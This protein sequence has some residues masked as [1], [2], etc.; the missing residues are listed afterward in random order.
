MKGVDIDACV[1]DTSNP[2]ITKTGYLGQTVR[3]H[4]V[5]LQGGIFLRLWDKQ[6]AL[7]NEGDYVRIRNGFVSIDH[8]Q[9][10]QHLNIGRHTTMEVEHTQ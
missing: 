1:V 3:T 7:V 6:I 2:I 5:K 8:A 10:I 4:V 9:G